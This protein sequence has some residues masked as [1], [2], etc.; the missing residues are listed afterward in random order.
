MCFIESVARVWESAK[1]ERETIYSRRK[2]TVQQIYIYI[3]M[4]MRKR[5]LFINKKYI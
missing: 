3:Y 4:Y 2:Q 1:C 5:L